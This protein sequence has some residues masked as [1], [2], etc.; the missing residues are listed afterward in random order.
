MNSN[1]AFT[2]LHETRT[3]RFERFGGDRI[4][5]D[6]LAKFRFVQHRQRQ[7]EFQNQ[8]K[9]MVPIFGRSA[10]HCDELKQSILA[11]GL[12]ATDLIIHVIGVGQLEMAHQIGI[13]MFDVGA[14]LPAALVQLAVFILA[15]MLVRDI[16]DFEKCLA[17]SFV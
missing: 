10:L 4:E 1:H 11:T 5:F 13:A 12:N 3:N 14:D 17:I 15:G 8:R 16:V 6:V 9:P 7:I 2:D